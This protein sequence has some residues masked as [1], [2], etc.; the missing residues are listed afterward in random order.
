[1]IYEHAYVTI[2]PEQRAEFEEAFAGAKKYLVDANGGETAE[3]VRSVDH[4]G[5]YLLR[6][7]WNSV[8][9]HIEV[10]S[11]STNGKLLA[12]AIGGFFTE[13][14]QVVHFEDAPV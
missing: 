7:G 12:D 14:P 11:A 4:A 6:V 3:I 1:M 13:T 2:D 10:F 9:D 5:V 8:E